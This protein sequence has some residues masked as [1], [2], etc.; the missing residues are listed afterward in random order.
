[1][2]PDDVRYIILGYKNTDSDFRELK[3]L[4]TNVHWIHVGEGSFLWRDSNS[5]IDFIRRNIDNTKYKKYDIERLI[6][7]NER[8]MLLI[9]ESGMGKYTFLS[10]MEDKIKKWNPSVWLLRVNLHELQARL[11]ILTLENKV[12]TSGR[13]FYGVLP[14]HGKRTLWH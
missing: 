3:E 10:H 4:C 6:G 7:H 13:N 9:A 2:K 14:I 12:S 5:N 8:T 11:I 1:M